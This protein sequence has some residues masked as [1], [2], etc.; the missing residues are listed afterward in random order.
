MSHWCIYSSVIANVGGNGMLFWRYTSL[1]IKTHR[2][3]SW[4]HV[5]WNIFQPLDNSWTVKR[6]DIFVKNQISGSGFVQFVVLTSVREHFDQFLVRGEATH[7][8]YEIIKEFSFA[9]IYHKHWSVRTNTNNN[10][11]KQT[12]NNG[13]K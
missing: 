2:F 7:F 6:Q 4:L 10:Q 9:A 11:M 5:H 3:K 1:G 8:Y 12:Y 13:V